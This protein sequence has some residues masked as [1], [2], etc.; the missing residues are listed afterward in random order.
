MFRIDAVRAETSPGIAGTWRGSLRYGAF[1]GRVQASAWGLKPG[2]LGYLGRGGL[3]GSGA[4]T[5]ISGAG[6]ELSLVLRGRFR[7]YVSMAAEW[8]RKASGDES[9]L[10]AAALAW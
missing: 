3:P 5:T 8:R 9:L 4:F 2:Q 1:D 7:A 6:S 10:V